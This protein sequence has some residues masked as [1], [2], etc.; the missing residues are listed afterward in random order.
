MQY[1]F[2]KIDATGLKGN[3]GFQ[4][5]NICSCIQSVKSVLFTKTLSVVLPWFKIFK[6]K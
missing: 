2:E 3:T 1:S 5:L 4:F 6:S